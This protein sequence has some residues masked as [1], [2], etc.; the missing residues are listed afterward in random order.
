MGTE[1]TVDC[2]IDLF[3]LVLCVRSVL[4][5]TSLLPGT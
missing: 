1:P 2:F 3:Y 5:K 4:L